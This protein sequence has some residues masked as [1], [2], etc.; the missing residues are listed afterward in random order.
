MDKVIVYTVNNNIQM[1][2]SQNRVRLYTATSH[3]A[4][5]EN[6]NP[7]NALLNEDGS[8]IL[9]EDGSRLTLE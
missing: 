8:N 2:T 1:Y 9:N 7:G 4:I 3:Y 5:P 6:I